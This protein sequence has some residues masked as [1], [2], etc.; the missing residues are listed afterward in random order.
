MTIYYVGNA[1]NGIHGIPIGADG[2]RWSDW[3]RYV[4]IQPMTIGC[5]MPRDKDAKTVYNWADIGT[6]VSIVW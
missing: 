4:G 3:E 6:P 1:K 2:V 5:V